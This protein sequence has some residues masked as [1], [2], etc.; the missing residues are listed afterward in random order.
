MHYA[1]W[2]RR[3]GIIAQLQ[4]I[5]CIEHTGDI[6]K[7]VRTGPPASYPPSHLSMQRYGRCLQLYL[8]E[9]TFRAPITDKT[10]APRGPRSSRWRT[11]TRCAASSR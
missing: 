2:L 1:S 9:L 11:S 10:Y 5:E 3:E 6:F 8:L 4:Q 7:T